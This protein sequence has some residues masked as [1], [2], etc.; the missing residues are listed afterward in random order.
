MKQEI[1]T[2]EINLDDDFANAC[3][4]H[5]DDFLTT[6]ARNIRHACYKTETDRWAVIGLAHSLSEALD[7]C[8]KIREMLCKMHDR[9]PYGMEEL[10]ENMAY[11]KPD[12]FKN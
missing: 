5:V 8:Q 6:S 2:I 7:K 11:E 12:G 10:I 9:T 4:Y 1:F 3:A